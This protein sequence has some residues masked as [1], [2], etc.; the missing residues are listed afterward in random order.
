MNLI[1]INGAA[2]C[3]ESSLDQDTRPPKSAPG[4]E[5]LYCPKYTVLQNIEEAQLSLPPHTQL[6]QTV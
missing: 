5:H 2:S 3:P 1:E 4:P 6:R